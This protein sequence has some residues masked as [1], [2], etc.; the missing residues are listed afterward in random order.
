MK[1][2]LFYCLTA[3]FFVFASCSNDIEIKKPTEIPQVLPKTIT[4]QSKVNNEIQTNTFV[5]SGNKIVSVSRLAYD[6]IMKTVFTYNGNLITKTEG[7][8]NNEI[9]STTHYLYSKDKLKEAVLTLP[10]GSST[11]EFYVK[12]VYSHNADG[13]I[14]YETFRHDAPDTAEDGKQI[15]TFKNGNLAKISTEYSSQAPYTNDCEFNYDSKNN[16]LK[17]I[18]G[19]NLILFDG[20]LYNG[21]DM[22]N[23]DFG[24]NDFG[25]NNIIKK[26]THVR[27]NSGTTNYSEN[28]IY[29]Y[30]KNGYPLT[31]KSDESEYDIIYT[32]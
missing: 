15:L 10:N 24:I 6:K 26:I 23:G 5:Y 18:V 14:S 12:K 25:L 30:D 29:T 4:F 11:N 19:L 32:Y 13:T 27:D 20:N 28:Y 8:V 17:N 31:K 7:F 16:P 22:A 9:V 3:S 2:K 21:H 1:K